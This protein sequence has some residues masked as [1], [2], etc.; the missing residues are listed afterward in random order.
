MIDE[1]LGTADYDQM[2]ARAL[3]LLREHRGPFTLRLGFESDDG[4]TDVLIISGSSDYRWGCGIERHSHYPR[5]AA[6]DVGF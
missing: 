5:P 4:E 2:H 1:G 3:N 6:P